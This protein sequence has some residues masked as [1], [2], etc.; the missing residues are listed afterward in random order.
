[1]SRNSDRPL[2][3]HGRPNRRWRRLLRVTR[4]VEARRLTPEACDSLMRMVAA[5]CRPASLSLAVLVDS[6]PLSPGGRFRDAFLTE[7]LI[8]GEGA[9]VVSPSG[10]RIMRPEVAHLLARLPGIG[11]IVSRSLPPDEALVLNASGE[12]L[13]RITHIGN[14]TPGPSAPPS[15]ASNG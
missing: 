10:C 9:A 8:H 14:P 11:L 1:M 2:S 6:T 5:R 7:L 12:Q 3:L 13:L 4:S 15:G